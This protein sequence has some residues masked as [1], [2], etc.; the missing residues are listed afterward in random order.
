[1]GS[2]IPTAKRALMRETQE[3]FYLVFLC[4]QVNCIFYVLGPSSLLGY[5][6]FNLEILRFPSQLELGFSN[7]L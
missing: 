4:L 1:M 5:Y 3:D 2:F 6:Y 7:P